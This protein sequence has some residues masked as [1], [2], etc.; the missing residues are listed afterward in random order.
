MLHFRS[1]GCDMIPGTLAAL[2]GAGMMR[3]S[4]EL[5]RIG[6]TL[7]ERVQEKKHRDGARKRSRKHDNAR[8][9]CVWVWVY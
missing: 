3:D 5:A 7:Q 9:V 2:P 6:Q 8:A 4:D 1:A